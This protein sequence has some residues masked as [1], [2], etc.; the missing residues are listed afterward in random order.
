[1]KLFYGWKM[2]GAAF[3][4][5]FLLGAL[6][7]QAF[8]AYVAVLA[9]EFGWS[10]A[11]LSLGAAIQSVE[12]ALLGP[13]LGWVVDRFGAQGMIKA[14]VLA[15]GAGFLLLGAVDSLTGFYV[16]VAV[17][18]IGTSF[19]GYFPL[20]VAIVQWFEKKRARALAMMSMGLAVGGAVVPVV[21][22]SM[23][24]FGWRA[25]AF[26][27]GVIVIAVGWPLARI[28]RRHPEQMGETIDGEPQPAHASG[29]HPSAG[30]GAAPH[31]PQRQFTAAEALRTRAFW[32]LSIGHGFAL[33]VVST[34][35]VHAITHMSSGLGY[36][37][38]SASV[39]ITLMTFA[40]TGG[41]LLGSVFGD[42]FDKRWVSAA[43]MLMHVGGLLALCYA[44]STAWLIAF[45]VLHGLAWGLRGPLMQAIRADYFGR[46]AIGM[47]MGIS[48]LFIAVGQV[49]G[50]MTAG[51]LADRTGDY[52][53]GFTL[54]AIVAATGSIAFLAAKRPG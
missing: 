17:L 30:P 38:A 18:A 46:A 27:S 51:W 20:T 40:Q 13:V 53:I 26:G 3:G 9:A 14:G 35:N 49:V 15:F 23:Q 41:M 5:Q 32:L 39:F 36:S 6:L 31:A 54:L 10:K 37:I 50:P 33:L 44:T 11:S 12:A 19:S 4:L 16:A 29:A 34:V 7:L 52:R 42:R 21:A 25:T 48:A 2:V 28:F 47:I 43:C 45:G 8:G 22:W 1:M 24:T